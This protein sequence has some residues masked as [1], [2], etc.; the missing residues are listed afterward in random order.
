MRWTEDAIEMTL[1]GKEQDVP[2][3]LKDVQGMIGKPFRMTMSRRG[4]VLKADWTALEALGK[5]T[6]GMDLKQM[7]QASQPQLPAK[8]V[9]VG[10]TW[11]QQFEVK[12]PGTD[13]APAKS[14]VDVE[15]TY[16]GME[17]VGDVECAKIEMSGTVS[18]R[19]L[20]SAGSP[21]PG[22]EMTLDTMD[23]YMDGHL[24]FDPAAG[25]M[26]EQR[27]EMEMSVVATVRGKRGEGDKAE[28]FQITTDTEMKT[29]TVTKISF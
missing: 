2:P 26:V 10:D 15:Y 4:R 28:P 5:L 29:S 12:V 8:P 16:L 20:K 6:G 3:Q 7:M 1:N 23:M 14:S 19:G 13:A 27:I 24:Y 11:Q 17:P 18:L 25:Q 9:K 22:I 21:V